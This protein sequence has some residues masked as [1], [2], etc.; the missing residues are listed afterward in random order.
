M[1]GSRLSYIDASKK[2][3]VF[4][5][6]PGPG[7]HSFQLTLQRKNEKG[8]WTPLLERKSDAT[9]ATLKDLKPGA[10]QWK[11]TTFDENQKASKASDPSTFSIEELTKLEWASNE[12][13]LEHE[14][15]TPTPTLNA[16]WK[17]VANAHSY[18]YRLAAEGSE[19]DDAQKGTT[20]QN[21]LDIPVKADGRYSAVIEALDAKDQVLAIS[22]PKIYVVKRRPLLPAP[23]W[24]SSTPPVL[25]SDGKGNLSLAW[26]AVDGAKHY[27]LIMEDG[28]GQVI[29]QRAVERNTAS[30]KRLKPGLYQIK[31][32]PVDSYQ[33][34]GGESAPKTVEVPDTSDIRAPKI[35]A[36]KVK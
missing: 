16:Q 25:K 9:L 8:E 34:P 23:R 18:S 17:S 13:V 27:L 5:W 29:N 35:K 28:S 10:Y 30:V 1:Q 14:Y 15:T 11:V 21:L 6:Q 12:P 26:E 19:L 4:K 33:R 7:A 32:K 3:L 36:L 20:K 31:I 22:D 2:G 24:A